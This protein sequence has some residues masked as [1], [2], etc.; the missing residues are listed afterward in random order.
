MVEGSEQRP[1]D[2]LIPGYPLGRDLILDITIINP[3]Q[4]NAWP[5]AAFTAGV[6]ME[7]AKEKKRDTYRGKLRPNQ[8]F[9]PLA[10]ETLGGFD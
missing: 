7:R 4:K 8:I 1:G 2:V 6:A 3:L 5:E 10:F 9:K